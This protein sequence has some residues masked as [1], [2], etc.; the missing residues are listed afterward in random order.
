MMTQHRFTEQFTGPLFAGQFAALY[1]QRFS[2]RLDVQATDEQPLLWGIY[3]YMGRILYISG[4]R[5]PQRRLRRQFAQHC[6]QFDVH[7]LTAL[8]AYTLVTGECWEY[9]FLCALLDKGIVT[10]EQVVAIVRS[11]IDETLLDLIQVDGLSFQSHERLLPQVQLTVLSIEP[12]LQNLQQSWRSWC[13]TG[14][15]GQAL[16]RTP[17]IKMPTELHKQVSPAVYQSLKTWMDGQRTLRD[18][19]T[20]MRQDITTLSCSLVPYLQQGLIELVPVPDAPAL[21]PSPKPVL[22][23]PTGPLIACVD[24]SPQVCQMM[25]QLLTSAGYRF[26]AIQESV[27][28]M[29][30]LLQQ[31]PDLIFLD[32]VMPDTNGYEVC[33]QLRRV[34]AF[35]DIPVLILTGNDGLSD[36]IRARVAGSTDF[37]R[38]PIESTTLL[39][40]V[41]KYLYQPMPQLF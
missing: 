8:A 31:K 7:E 23:P 21:A 36:R 34:S 40:A 1:Y 26:V 32:L 5:H 14:L 29:P 19:A 37:I 41:R 39:A 2:G 33:S 15:H 9:Q 4:G 18:I 22:L 38:K 28:A 25:K 3:F 27:R 16:H 35:K 17:V 20:Q 12:V 30:I 6:P 13:T 11:T 10:R 24:D